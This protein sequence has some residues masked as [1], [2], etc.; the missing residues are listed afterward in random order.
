MKQS[1]STEK[2]VLTISSFVNQ[3]NYDPILLLTKLFTR[4]IFNVII[5]V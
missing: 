5:L 2:V 3:K 4:R 1:P